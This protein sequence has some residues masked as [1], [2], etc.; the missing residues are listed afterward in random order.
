MDISIFSDDVMAFRD[1]GIISFV[2]IFSLLAP[3]TLNNLIRSRSHASIPFNIVIIVTMVL[4]R[5][6]LNIIDLA[7]APNQIIIR[8]PRAILGKLLIA[9]RKG[10]N[11]CFNVLN[12]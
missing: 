12:E 11:I 7:V 8:G 2:S 4:M 5:S 3:N 10:S 9:T 1:D 6:E